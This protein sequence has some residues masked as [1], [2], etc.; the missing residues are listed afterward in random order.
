[1]SLLNSPSSKE[2][3]MLY[4][5]ILQKG[6]PESIKNLFNRKIGISNEHYNFLQHYGQNNDLGPLRKLRQFYYEVALF[7]L[8]HGTKT[9]DFISETV[10]Q[11]EAESH[12]E[13]FADTSHVKDGV[14]LRSSGTS[15]I[16]S[17]LQQSERILQEYGHNPKLASF[18]DLGCG[19]GKSLLIARTE[20]SF[21][22][23]VGIDYYKEVLE[24]AKENR[25]KMGLSNGARKIALH[26]AD[27]AQ[28]KEY[29]GPTIVYMYNPFGENVMKEVEK[30][31]RET[32]EQCI[33]AYNK[34]LHGELFK[35]ENGW[36]RE[37]SMTNSDPDNTL[38]IY[39]RGLEC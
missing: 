29:K 11:N 14:K 7:D 35:E 15:I 25:E 31:L 9:A 22:N 37:F 16:K 20:H 6:G 36:H 13:A 21:D 28:F 5:K 1:M 27:A 38:M 23:V 24:T 12:P 4:E 32:T 33:V 26:F 30:N 19:P 8:T 2:T 17:A 39:R 18:Y 10:Y 34:P 3:L